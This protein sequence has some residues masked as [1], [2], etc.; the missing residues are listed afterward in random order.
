MQYGD[1]WEYAYTANAFI[2]I[3]GL[4]LLVISVLVE[5]PEKRVIS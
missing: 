4:G 3:I 1:Q 2:K 5:A